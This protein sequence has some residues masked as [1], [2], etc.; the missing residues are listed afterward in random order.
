MPNMGRE[1]SHGRIGSK[2][3]HARGMQGLAYAA[4]TPQQL[5]GGP[6]GTQGYPRVGS[7]VK[8]V[9]VSGVP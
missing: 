2:A 9:M 7:H 5:C 6:V 8:G 3:A 4:S 1:C